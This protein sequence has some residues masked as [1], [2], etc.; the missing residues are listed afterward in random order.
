MK[1]CPKCKSQILDDVKFCPYCGAN[2]EYVPAETK[3]DTFEK[4]KSQASVRGHDTYRDNNGA[5]QNF[6]T[7]VKTDSQKMVVDRNPQYQNQK[8]LESNPAIWGVIG[9]VLPIFGFLLYFT[10]RTERPK[11][12][13]NARNGAL[14][15]TI[16]IIFLVMIM[17]CS[18]INMTDF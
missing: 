2:V 13:L 16:L 4:G 9:F 8:P 14:V 7:Y 11:D 18:M 3:Y 12:A 10:W 6:E 17:S 1:K 5:K 15:S